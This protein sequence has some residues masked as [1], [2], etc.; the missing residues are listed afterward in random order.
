MVRNV[1]MVGPGEFRPMPG[2]VIGATVLGAA[3]ELLR[4]MAQYRMLVYG[5]LLVVLMVFRPNGLLGGVNFT[6]LLLRAVGR[7][8]AA[9]RVRGE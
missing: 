8:P 9:G 5:V 3:P 6:A 7:R 2:A 1:K 4:F